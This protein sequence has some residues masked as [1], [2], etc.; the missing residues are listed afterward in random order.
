M[1]VA[2]E[3]DRFKTLLAQYKKD[4]KLFMQQRRNEVLQRVMTNANYVLVLPP[5]VNGQPRTIWLP[6]GPEAKPPKLP[7]RPPAG[8]EHP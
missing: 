3:A 6:V 2:A 1:R 7:E 5:P 4:P 8:E